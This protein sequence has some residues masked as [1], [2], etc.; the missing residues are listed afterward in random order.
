MLRSL[1]PEH[2]QFASWTCTIICLITYTLFDLSRS[3]VVVFIAL[4]YLV[5]SDSCLAISLRG[6]CILLYWRQ[7]PVS[8]GIPYASHF[9]VS[10]WLCFKFCYRYLFIEHCQCTQF[11]TLRRKSI[12]CLTLSQV[13]L[14][15]CALVSLSFPPLSSGLTI[16]GFHTGVLSTNLFFVSFASSTFKHLRGSGLAEKLGLKSAPVGTPEPHS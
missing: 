13:K 8:M 14:A 2:H 11:F 4:E 10:F 12:Q 1:S 6:Q 9:L 5:K 3:Q 15:C 16:K 7:W